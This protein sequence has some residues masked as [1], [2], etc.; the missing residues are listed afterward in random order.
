MVGWAAR[1]LSAKSVPELCEAREMCGR[2][3][4]ASRAGTV[5]RKMG[6]RWSRGTGVEAPKLGLWVLA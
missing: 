6:R 5:S 4:W 2:C 3:R 1:R